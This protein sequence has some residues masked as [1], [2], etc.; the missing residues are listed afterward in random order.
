MSWIFSKDAYKKQLVKSNTR[1]DQR[2]TSVKIKIPT[3]MKSNVV[4]FTKHCPRL[5]QQKKLS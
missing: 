1:K 4:R 5:C 2:V 3:D